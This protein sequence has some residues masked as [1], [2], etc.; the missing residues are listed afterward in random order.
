MQQQKKVYT[1]VVIALCR[2]DVQL[3]ER[4]DYNLQTLGMVFDCFVEIT[5]GKIYVA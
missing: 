5:C 1:K 4:L 2:A 3:A